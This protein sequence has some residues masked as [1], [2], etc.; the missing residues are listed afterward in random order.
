M[1]ERKAHTGFCPPRGLQMG[2]SLTVVA[3]TQFRAF[4]L[5]ALLGYGKGTSKALVS[6][7]QL[8]LPT[9]EEI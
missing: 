5:V 8:P 6:G 2:N 7:Q 3:Y 9:Q 1:Q 4:P